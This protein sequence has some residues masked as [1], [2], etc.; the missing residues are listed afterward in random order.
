M[1]DQE[2]LAGA[3]TFYWVV[4]D[5]SKSEIEVWSVQEKAEARLEARGGVK[6]PGLYLYHIAEDELKRAFPNLPVVAGD[7]EVD[8]SNKYIRKG[9]KPGMKK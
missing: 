2:N 7:V 4:S 8:T 6:N 1:S 9:W 3:S 5:Q